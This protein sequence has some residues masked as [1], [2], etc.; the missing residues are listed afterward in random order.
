MLLYFEFEDKRRKAEVVWP[1]NSDNIVVHVND[2]DLAQKLPTDFYYE[3]NRHNKID[4]IIE[5]STNKRLVEL[6]SV[7]GRKL[8]ELVNR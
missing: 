3:L 1:K 5:D 4:F 8:Q 2:T 7:I 6:Q